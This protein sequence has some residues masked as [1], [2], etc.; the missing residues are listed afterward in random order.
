MWEKNCQAT[1]KRGPTCQRKSTWAAWCFQFESEKYYQPTW[2]VT[3]GHH[4]TN[5]TSIVSILEIHRNSK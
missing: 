4:L 3:C 1:T 2:V 5:C